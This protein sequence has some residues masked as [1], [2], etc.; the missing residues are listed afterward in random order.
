MLCLCSIMRCHR[1]YGRN[2]VSDACFSCVGG[3]F[4]THSC[5]IAES[6]EDGDDE[7]EAMRETD[8]VKERFLTSHFPR[9]FLGLLSTYD[10][11]DDR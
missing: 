8:V 7:R 11:A 1:Q 6:A 3:I 9:A 5:V 10:T 2:R 4:V